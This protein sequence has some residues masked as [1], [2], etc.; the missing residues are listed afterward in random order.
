MLNNVGPFNLNAA[1]GDEACALLTLVDKAI[2]FNNT[3]LA[4]P[5]NTI[6]SRESDAGRAK[7]M[8]TIQLKT[9][10]EDETQSMMD[11]NKNKT[12]SA[13]DEDE[14]DESAGSLSPVSEEMDANDLSYNTAST[15]D[16]SDVE[17]MDNE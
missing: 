12:K 4:R 8:G 13:M 16:E 11:K 1:A 5:D 3:V 14:D 15:S 9:T 6:S 2:P 10:I 17:L 7:S